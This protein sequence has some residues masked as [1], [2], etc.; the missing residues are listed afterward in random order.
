[1]LAVAIV[2]YTVLFIW[3]VALFALCTLLD[4]CY[5]ILLYEFCAELT[6]ASAIVEYKSMGTC[7]TLTI[8][9]IPFFAKLGNAEFAILAHCKPTVAL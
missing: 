3:S 7:Y 5:I 8:V 4:I 1:M 6:F 2:Y 9:Y